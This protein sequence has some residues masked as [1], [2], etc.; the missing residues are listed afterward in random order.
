MFKKEFRRRYRGVHTDHYRFTK[1]QTAR[2]PRNKIPQ[3]FA[4]RCKG[5][6]Q[7]IKVKSDYPR[8]Q[9][10]NRENADRI[11]LAC[12]VSGLTGVPDRQVRRRKL[13]R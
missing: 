11:L 9:C 6:A 10:L 4:D 1:L 7:K 5:L 2:Q 12:F 3:Q 13:R 8:I